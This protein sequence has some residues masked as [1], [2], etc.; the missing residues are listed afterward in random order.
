M[1]VGTQIGLD[2]LVRRREREGRKQPFVKPK[3]APPAEPELQPS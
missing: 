2:A 3:A 1:L